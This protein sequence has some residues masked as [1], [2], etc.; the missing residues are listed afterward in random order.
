MRKKKSFWD[1]FDLDK[2][3]ADAETI[4][5]NTAVETHYCPNYCRHCG[6]KLK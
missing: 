5:K 4:R 1:E 3:L 6:T 2:F